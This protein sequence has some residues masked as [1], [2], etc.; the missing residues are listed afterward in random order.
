MICS[1]KE[2]PGY[3]ELVPKLY[4]TEANAKWLQ[5][6]VHAVSMASFALVRRMGDL[7]LVQARRHYGLALHS[8]RLALEDKQRAMSSTVL[9]SIALLWKYDVRCSES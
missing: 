8:L 1:T 2:F 6:S 9:V 5:E 4:D 7:Y 3:L